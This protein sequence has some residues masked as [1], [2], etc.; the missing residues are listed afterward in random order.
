VLQTGSAIQA[1]DV[2]TN[3]GALVD[4]LS[5]TLN[6]MLNNSHMMIWGTANLSQTGATNNVCQ[7]NIEVDGVQ[8]AAEYVLVIPGFF[9]QIAFAV[10]TGALAAG[11]HT[12]KL[13]W[14]TIG[15]NTLQIRAAT[16]PQAEFAALTAQEVTG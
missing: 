3:S 9:G 15:G 16:V 4:L 6:G 13:R 14:A 8:V 11:N 1:A 7:F 2:S 5:V 10:R 12:A